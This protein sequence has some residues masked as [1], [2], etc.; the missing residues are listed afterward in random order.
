L[1]KNKNFAKVFNELEVFDD[2]KKF[3]V[4]FSEDEEVQ[5][6]MQVRKLTENND[7][8]NSGRQCLI[9]A[10]ASESMSL[11]K[12]DIK[13]VVD[14]I[15]KGRVGSEDFSFVIRTN[16]PIVELKSVSNESDSG[17]SEKMRRQMMEKMK[18]KEKSPEILGKPEKNPLDLIKPLQ[19]IINK[20]RK[21]I[22]LSIKSYSTY[23]PPSPS[24]LLKNSLTSPQNHREELDEVLNKYLQSRE[25]SEDFEKIRKNFET[26]K[27]IETIDKLEN[28]SRTS[29]SGPNPEQDSEGL[30]QATSKIISSPKT[31][32]HDV[33][34]SSLLS[35]ISDSSEIQDELL[36]FLNINQPLNEVDLE[37][38]PNR[39]YFLNQD[40]IFVEEGNSINEDFQRPKESS[41]VVFLENED[42][43]NFDE[44]KTENVLES[45]LKPNDDWVI[46]KTIHDLIEFI[47]LECVCIEVFNEYKSKNYKLLGNSAVIMEEACVFTSEFGIKQTSLEIF[48]SLDE[49]L[50]KSAIFDRD[51]H[52]FNLG[53][54]NEKLKESEK[55]IKKSQI[56]YE[57]PY[58]GFGKIH[59]KCIFDLIDS[60]LVLHRK[61]VNHPAWKLG[62]INE[63]I[64][65]FNK[66]IKKFIKW[67]ERFCRVCSGKIPTTD[68]VLS[69][70]TLDEDLLQSIREQG[71]ERILFFDI[72]EA[73]SL[74]TDYE[75]QENLL[76][77]YVADLIV[78]DLIEETEGLLKSSLLVHKYFNSVIE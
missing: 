32:D 50:L 38:E 18:Q 53:N 70:G 22:F 68:M 63:K 78:S 7:E 49:D 40:L 12:V 4:C 1:K 30:I 20:R 23:K 21:Q 67:A 72:I 60:F 34:S 64:W 31:K 66:I 15:V 45:N 74:W 57:N 2:V 76:M 33:D 27:K 44:F 42:F 58:V 62:K 11:G 52:L 24:E 43:F 9:F 35:I 75:M 29:K 71:L 28:S 10:E 47:Y 61:Q 17:L 59:N 8:V 14:E 41:F 56:L 54:F 65:D 26:H 16:M 48:S 46:E 5:N 3:S 39:P 37:P 36:I 25:T 73:E 6:I 69:D 13:D 55:I 19:K 77:I 51:F